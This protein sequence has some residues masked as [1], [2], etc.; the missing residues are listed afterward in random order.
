MWCILFTE[1]STSPSEETTHF[2]KATRKDLFSKWRKF[3]WIE[4]W[5]ER[6]YRELNYHLTKFLTRHRR[7]KKYFHCFGPLLQIHRYTRTESGAY[8]VILFEVH[9]C[10]KEIERHPQWSYRTNNF[11]EEILGLEAHWSMTNAKIQKRFQELN[12][13]WKAHRMCIC[14]R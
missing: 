10:K 1:K 7:Y 2:R 3:H 9:R 11:L 13:P 8:Y 14:R 6:R 5:I 4:K 12:W